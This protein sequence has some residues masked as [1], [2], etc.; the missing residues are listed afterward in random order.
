MFTP[1]CLDSSPIE[2]FS[3][4]EDVMGLNEIVLDPVVTTGCT[5]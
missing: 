5:V 1:L 4:R 2:K 3:A